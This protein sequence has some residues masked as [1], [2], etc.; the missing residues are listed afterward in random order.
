[1]HIALFGGAFDPPHL[2]HQALTLHVLATQNVDQVWWLPTPVHPFAKNMAS[3]SQR[4]VMCQLALRHF[5]VH[6][7]RLCEIE[8]ALPAPNYTV[9]TV[10]AL[11]KRHPGWDF[12]LV[13][14]S[15]NVDRLDSWHD[16][17][18][19]RS[20]CQFIVVPRAGHKHGALLPQISSTEVRE[21]LGHARLPSRQVDQQVLAYIQQHKLYVR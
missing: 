13:I 1:M 16:I 11:Q 21:T 8:N 5:D 15:D 6:K 4:L 20:L 2:G 17:A 19:L 14:G 18:R 3:W 9:E 12:S 7:V 10:A